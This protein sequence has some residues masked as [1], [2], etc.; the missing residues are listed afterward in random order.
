MNVVAIEGTLS[1]P[2]AWRALPSGDEVVN[3][4]VS[5]RDDGQRAVSVPVAWF[6]AP[7]RARDLDEGDAVFVVGQV[8]RRFFRAGGAT[9][10]RTE[11][12]ADYVAAGSDRRRRQAALRRALERIEESAD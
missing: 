5:V 4:E 7:A 9:G 12:V 6:G 10:S 8:R 3:L 1:R 2:A 11:V